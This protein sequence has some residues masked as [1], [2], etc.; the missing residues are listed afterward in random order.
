MLFRSRFL[1]LVDLDRA[2]FAAAHARAFLQ[3][4]RVVRAGFRALAALDALALIDDRT[5]V[6]YR[7]S[8]ARADLGATVRDTA[9]ARGRY[10][11]TVDGTFVAGYIYDLDDIGIGLVAAHSELE[12]LLKYG[13]FFIYAATQARLRSR[14]YL[15]RDLV[16]Y[17]IV[18]PLVVSPDQF[19]KDLVFKLLYCG[20]EKSGFHVSP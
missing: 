8:A 1:V 10:E 9:A 14:H 13:A 20:I 6:H 4:Y 12:P 19:D 17:V 3:D 2:G 18:E 16:V 5:L 7:D 15:D 11:Y